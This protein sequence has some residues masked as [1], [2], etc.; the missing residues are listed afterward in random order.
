MSQPSALEAHLQE[1][2]ARYQEMVVTL[3]SALA[4]D[5]IPEADRAHAEEMLASARSM[6]LSTRQEIDH[7]LERER[8]LVIARGGK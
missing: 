2:L 3:I 1:Q 4:A 6:V 7:A 8:I 5:R